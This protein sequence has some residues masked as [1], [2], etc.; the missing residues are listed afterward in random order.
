MPFSEQELE[1][2]SRNPVR[3]RAWWWH[4]SMHQA[5]LAR[6]NLKQS[7]ATGLLHPVTNYLPKFEEGYDLVHW[8]GVHTGVSAVITENLDALVRSSLEPARCTCAHGLRH[9]RAA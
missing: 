9:K 5:R 1:D 4:M 3:L 7:R 2:I 6:K 8:A